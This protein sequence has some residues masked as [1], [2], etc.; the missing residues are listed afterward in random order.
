MLKA[1]DVN[2]S[3]DRRKNESGL[4]KDS[5]FMS[6]FFRIIESKS[7]RRLPFK[8]QVFSFPEHSHIRTRLT[9][10]NEVIATAGRISEILGLNTPLCLAIAAGHDIGHAPYGHLGEELL[11]ELGK[12]LFRHEIYGT[13]LLQEVENRGKGLNLCYE[14]LEGI[15]MH[16]RGAHEL[17]INSS[18]PAEYSAVMY[19]DKISYTF[20]DYSD[21]DRYGYF[22]NDEYKKL[23]QSINEKLGR[24]TEARRDACIKALVK[25]S[26]EKGC[27]SFTEGEE[28][29]L[30]D[31]LRAVLYKRV[32]EAIDTSV[33]KTILKSLYAFIKENEDF[34]SKYNS[35]DPIIFI[36][37]LTD[38]N[39]TTFG[40]MRLSSK[41]L[42]LNDIERQFRG[43]FELLPELKDKKIDY[44][45]AGLDW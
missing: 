19:A 40:T 17:T 24:T 5:P 15:R 43:A 34:K 39:V 25:E 10:T 7:F 11:S 26:K 44:S 18:K 32:Y 12:K 36:S 16:A 22:P 3:K 13:V 21:A 35:F 31:E 28:F 37:L 4:A 6:D 14:T 41:K 33:H 23:V 1:F 38:E 9:H 27:V 42:S 29:A 20:S 8:T 2:D 45:D 30:F